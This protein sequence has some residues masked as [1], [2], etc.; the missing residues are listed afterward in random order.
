MVVRERE[1]VREVVGDDG[2]HGFGGLKAGVSLHLLFIQG[3]ISH[4]FA[5]KERA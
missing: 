4:L 2:G 5:V 3:H 1:V